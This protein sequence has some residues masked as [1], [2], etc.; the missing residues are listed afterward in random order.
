MQ[1]LRYQQSPATNHLA[2]QA[3]HMVLDTADVPKNGYVSAVH[4]IQP[5][6]QMAF[7]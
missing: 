6:R 1:A 3:L 2:M 7:L 5:I 4:A